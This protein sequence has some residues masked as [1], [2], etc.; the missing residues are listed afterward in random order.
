M[1][2]IEAVRT[3]FNKYITFSGRA[4]RAEY[5]WFTLF[6]WGSLL[7]IFFIE[8][9]LQ[10]NMYVTI[11]WYLILLIPN[12]SVLVRRLHDTNRSGF[13]VFITII[14]TIGSIILFIFSAIAGT[15]GH[16]SY[17]PDPYDAAVENFF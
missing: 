2:F 8:A 9:Y 7:L 16:N 6:H 4:P 15:K 3:C 10:A 12:L 11:V 1:G 14:P 17:G 13:W 5:W